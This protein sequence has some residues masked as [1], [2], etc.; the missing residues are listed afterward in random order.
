MNTN[1][2]Y[3]TVRFYFNFPDDN[4]IVKKIDAA[5]D[6]IVDLFANWLGIEFHHITPTVSYRHARVALELPVPQS[7]LAGLEA[8]IKDIINKLPAKDAFKSCELGAAGQEIVK[9]NNL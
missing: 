8:K 9:L 2:I 4:L 7:K 5:S 3:Y 6:A 1:V